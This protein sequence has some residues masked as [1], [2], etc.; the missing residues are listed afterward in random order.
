VIG[1]GGKIIQS[2]QE[3]TGTVIAIDEIDNVDGW[4]YPPPTRLPS[5]RP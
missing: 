2:I 1:P 5:K 3:E 4:R